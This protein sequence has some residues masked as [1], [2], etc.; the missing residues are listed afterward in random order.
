[1]GTKEE[2]WN[3]NRRVSEGLNEQKAKRK[4]KLFRACVIKSVWHQIKTKSPS[5]SIL[6]KRKQKNLDIP[7]YPR[8][9]SI[10]KSK[11]IFSDN[12]IFHLSVIY[13]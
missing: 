3:G 9:R 4:E 12:F 11:T 6:F 1:M 13:A 10:Q 7:D 2:R 5:H 8:Y